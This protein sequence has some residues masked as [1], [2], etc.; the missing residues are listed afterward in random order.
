MSAVDPLLDHLVY[1]ASDL[2]HAVAAF[3]E[4]T[5]VAPTPGGRHPGQGTRNYLVGLG[6]TAYL[7]IIGPD[8]EH[9]AH[10]AKPFG[11][12]ELT[13][14]RLVTWAVHPRD[15]DTAVAAARAAGA[16][17]G[18]PRPM[19]R[20]TPGGEVLSWRLASA[21]PAPYD[22]VVPFLIDWGM[23][24]HPACSGL[25]QAELHAFSGTH[26][27]ATDVAGVLDAVGVILPVGAG[28][29]GLRAEITGPR[30]SVTL[31]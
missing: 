30:G 7:E 5:G 22:G 10:G 27:V 15:L 3:E 24:P 12:D 26:P 4:A 20:E 18:A 11:L 1:A 19:S 23:S 25:P 14:P 17:L 8:P 21:Q 13:A 31:R 28:A 29:A 16:D 6:E 2:A 9:P